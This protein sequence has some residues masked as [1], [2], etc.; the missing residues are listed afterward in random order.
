LVS[1][2]VSAKK[3]AE[4]LT[5]RQRVIE[6]L[7]HREPD[8]VPIDLGSTV[9][10][11]ISRRALIRFL[12][13][14]GIPH[15]EIGMY[16][17]VQQLG[18]V[19]EN[20]LRHL[21][22]DVRALDPQ[23][24]S[25]W[26]LD[27]VRQGDS[28]IFR[29]EWGIGWRKPVDSELY[30]D[31]FFHPLHAAESKCDIDKHPWPD[32]DDPVR[33]EMLAAEAE[34]IETETGAAIV[35][36][37]M[38]PGILEVAAWTRGF[39]SFYADLASD[40]DLV[41]ALLDRITEIKMRYWELALAEV[42]DRIVVVSEADDMASQT[43]LMMSKAT[44]RRLVKPRHKMLID[45]IKKIAPDAFVFFHSCG[46]ISELIPDLIEVGV[47]ILNPVQVSASGMDSK[48]LKKEF[49]DCITFWGGGVD[50]Q[51]VLPNG[52]PQD[53]RDEVKR[54]IDDLA[55]GGGFVF[56]TVHNIQADVPPENIAAMYE[57]LHEF[58]TY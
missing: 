29:D 39:E 44:Y 52:T 4:E 17:V 7:N 47:D 40:P 36:G 12:D 19:P 57:A 45:H 54:R 23:K 27:I 37:R 46:A 49:G 16:D 55:P 10:T 56:N 20:A 24:S 51:R 5:P 58:G 14:S 9:V 13:F 50:T 35:L 3:G 38:A 21:G 1:R 42:R 6:A 33:Y 34:R 22:V 28:D 11:G 18:L 15:D 30:F 48:Q 8:R 26:Q 31:M 53:V 43:G 32:P 2:A 25:K 41:C